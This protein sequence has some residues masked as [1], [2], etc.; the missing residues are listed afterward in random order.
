MTHYNR[1]EIEF[2]WL[3][4]VFQE[5]DRVPEMDNHKPTADISRGSWNPIASIGLPPPLGPYAIRP[6]ERGTQP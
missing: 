5:T 6:S 3:D 4:S 2:G 1:A